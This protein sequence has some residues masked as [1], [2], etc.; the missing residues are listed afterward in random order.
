M[1]APAPQRKPSILR[2]LLAILLCWALA[3]GLLL[4]VMGE[5]AVYSI[6]VMAVLFLGAFVWDTLKARA[7]RDE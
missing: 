2:G 5:T 3:S 6:V 1:N 7:K 4:L